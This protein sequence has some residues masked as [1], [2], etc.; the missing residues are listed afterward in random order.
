[1]AHLTGRMSKKVS[2]AKARQVH[3]KYQSAKKSYMKEEKKYMSA[4]KAYKKLYPKMKMMKMKK[5]M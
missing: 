1:M 2:P 3:K 4:S 5:M